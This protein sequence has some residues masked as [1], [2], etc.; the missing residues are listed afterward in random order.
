MTK[1]VAWNK[2]NHEQFLQDLDNIKFL[3]HINVLSKYKNDREKVLIQCKYCKKTKEITPHDLKQRKTTCIKCF[4]KMNSS[5]RACTIRNLRPD[6]VKY[7]EDENDADLY[8]SQSKS[9][10]WWVCPYCGLKYYRIV[11]KVSNYGFK[12]CLSKNGISFPNRLFRA[13]FTIKNINFYPEKT[14]EWAKNDNDNNYRYDYY[15]PDFNI[16]VE[17]NGSQHYNTDTFNKTSKKQKEIDNKK[18]NLAQNNGIKKYH[19]IN[20][21][22]SDF[23][24]IKNNIINSNLLEDLQIKISD[25]EWVEIGKKTLD[26]L[27]VKILNCYKNGLSSTKEIAKTL[28]V[29]KITVIKYLNLASSI[30]IC[31]YNSKEIL[32]KNKFSKKRIGMY[33]LENNLINMFDSVY[34]SEKYIKLNKPFEYKYSGYISYCILRKNGNA[35][36]YKWKYLEGGELN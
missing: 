12:C 10:V 18:K 13:L 26:L 14:F 16:I 31:D 30:G 32:E 21:S 19:S 5:K 35:Y 24:F 29:S 15:L 6:L 27:P 4:R 9:K 3:E 17:V 36:G 1:R 33:D 20:C 34:E 8:T 2:K 28:N 11:S 23:N 25:D 7:L 22:K